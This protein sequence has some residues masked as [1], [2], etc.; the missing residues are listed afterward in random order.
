MVEEAQWFG[1]YA[2][3]QGRGKRKGGAVEWGRGGAAGGGGRPAGE[4]G[5]CG[6]EDSSRP[7]LAHGWK[8][9][10]Q[11]LNVLE[12]EEDEAKEGTKG[13]KGV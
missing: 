12:V 3:R 5:R 9:E 13:N 6:Q 10:R 7:W 8:K 1:C 11:K 2:W 4:V